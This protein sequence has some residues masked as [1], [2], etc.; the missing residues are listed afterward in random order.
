M[1]DEKKNKR[2][3][4]HKLFSTQI[5]YKHWVTALQVRDKNALWHNSQNDWACKSCHWMAVNKWIQEWY[6]SSYTR[7]IRLYSLYCTSNPQ[8]IDCIYLFGQKIKI[9]TYKK[10]AWVAYTLSRASCIKMTMNKLLGYT[11]VRAQCKWYNKLYAMDFLCCWP[12][13]NIIMKISNMSIK[14]DP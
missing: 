14:Y 10:A 9:S 5:S 6:L 7:N 12:Y 2:W 11:Q 3:R 4:Y 1:R 8:S 13:G